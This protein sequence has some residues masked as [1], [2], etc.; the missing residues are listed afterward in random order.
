M[1]RPD[2]NQAARGMEKKSRKQFLKICTLWSAAGSVALN[3]F[4]FS[5]PAKTEKAKYITT[6]K[7]DDGL[8][9]KTALEEIRNK[10]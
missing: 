7:N 4:L 8:C 3:A 5:Q 2:A 1:L 9:A 6:Q 10:K